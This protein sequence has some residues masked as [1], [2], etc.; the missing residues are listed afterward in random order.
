[1]DDQEGGEEDQTEHL[2]SPTA[3]PSKREP[4]TRREFAS[5]E[6]I[7]LKGEAR[8]QGQ[9]DPER[10][11]PPRRRLPSEEELTS[12]GQVLLPLEADALQQEAAPREHAE[13]AEGQQEG[14]EIPLRKKN[15]IKKSGKRGEKQ[16]SRE[17]QQQVL[18]RKDL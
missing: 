4:S 7:G 15:L 13:K 11:I 9:V 17:A 8:P 16:K 12:E 14:V 10:R 3:T 18:R 1:M 2:A 5:E 6:E